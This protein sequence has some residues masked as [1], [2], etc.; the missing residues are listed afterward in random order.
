MIFS[1][2][3]HTLGQIGIMLLGTVVAVLLATLFNN[4]DSK[5]QYPTSWGY[6]FG[7]CT[8]I[9]IEEYYDVESE[10]RDP[11]IQSYANHGSPAKSDHRI[12]QTTVPGDDAPCETKNVIKKRIS[13]AKLR[14]RTSSF[15]ESIQ[16]ESHNK[17]ENERSDEVIA[18]A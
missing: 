3:S 6:L 17:N 1:S 5:R 12:A 9:F 7:F 4:L 2:G 10:R 18:K 11:V 15:L 8:D 16:G 13:L 14:R